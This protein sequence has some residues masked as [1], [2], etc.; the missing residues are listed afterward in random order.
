MTGADAVRELFPLSEAIAPPRPPAIM[1][2][3]E[4]DSDSLVLA[5][6]SSE[7]RRLVEAI[8]RYAD[9]GEGGGEVPQG[10]GGRRMG[11]DHSVGGDGT[12]ELAAG[13]R[14]VQPAG[15]GGIQ[16]G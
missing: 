14:G 8:G 16:G 15:S 5:N 4:S 6:V 2:F 3:L 13:G 9:L 11:A 1:S 7:G 12:V 10:K